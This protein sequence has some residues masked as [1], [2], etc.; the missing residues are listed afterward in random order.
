MN[1]QDLI[2][3][4]NEKYPIGSKVMWR[5]VNH[6]AYEHKQYE[7]REPAYLMT[8]RAVAF[9]KDKAGCVSIA[10]EFVDY[11]Y[12]PDAPYLQ[13]QIRPSAPKETCGKIRF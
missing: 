3:K 11:S 4:F 1:T 8:G 2:N 6:P 13:T 5:S 7:V 9:L 12:Q 10:P